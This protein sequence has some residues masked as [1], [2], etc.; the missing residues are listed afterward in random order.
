MRRQITSNSWIVFLGE[1]P[2][3]P[4]RLGHVSLILFLSAFQCQ[5][6][7]PTGPARHQEPVSRQPSLANWTDELR[8][9]SRLRKER[10]SMEKKASA[11]KAVREIRRGPLAN[12]PSIVPRSPTALREQ[13]GPFPQE[14]TSCEYGDGS[15][16]LPLL[17]IAS[18]FLPFRDSPRDR[19]SRKV[20]LSLDHPNVRL[21]LTGCRKVQL[22]GGHGGQ[23]NA[24]GVC[25]A[26]PGGGSSTTI[27]R[28]RNQAPDQRYR[29][30]PCRIDFPE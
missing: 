17:S 13:S 14:R 30:G 21:P 26:L 22:I 11:E 7:L 3:P 20:S 5:A 8:E 24:F 29:D 6:H 19:R 12:G 18:S 2:R 1:S 25:C 27:G 10:E 4:F 23:K 28:R 9:G 16:A 15:R